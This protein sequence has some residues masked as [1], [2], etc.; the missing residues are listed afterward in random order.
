MTSPTTGL[1]LRTYFWPARDAKAVVLLAHG[2]GSYLLHEFLKPTGVGLP[3]VYEGSWVQ[4]LND[5][6]FSV[7]GLDQIG[8]GFSAGLRG[9]RCHFNHFP[10]LVT[11]VTAFARFVTER[12]DMPGF[13]KGLPLFML[14]CSM[15]GAVTA[16]TLHNA[17]PGLFRGAVMLAPMLSLERISRKG[18]NPYLRLLS[19][20]L[21]TWAPALQVVATEKSPIDEQLQMQWEQDPHT[22]SEPTRVRVAHEYVLATEYLCREMS[23][24]DFPFLVFHSER[25]TMCD[26]DGSKRLFLTAKS[27]DKQ[28]RLVN[29]MWHVIVKEQD[30]ERVLKHV[31][32]WMA[33][34]A[35]AA[36]PAEAKSNGDAGEHAA[37]G[38]EEA[39]GTAAAA[40]GADTGVGTATK[41]EAASAETFSASAAPEGLAAATN[42]S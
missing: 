32:A 26:P 23:S 35:T 24:M 41:A 13:G 40:G 37:I 20:V 9:L 8:H 15:G 39:N 11:D 6:G 42:G 31:I 18:L 28:L 38:S 33:E 14:G 34:R 30:N 22:Y 3:C 27:K 19:W 16:Y 7:C 4:A 12:T 36:A 21:S 5:A 1:E 25:D 10:D 2:H 17:P 29:D